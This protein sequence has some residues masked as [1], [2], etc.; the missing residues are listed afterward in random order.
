M[1]QTQTIVPNNQFLLGGDKDQA[2]ASCGPRSPALLDTDSLWAWLPE[3][4]SQHVVLGR[5]SC[6]S[7]EY[8]LNPGRGQGSGWAWFLAGGCGCHLKA[9]LLS[10]SVSLLGKQENKYPIGE[11]Q[12]PNEI[13]RSRG[14]H[15]VPCQS[16]YPSTWHG[17]R[18][19]VGAQWVCNRCSMNV[20]IWHLGCL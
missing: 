20:C 15:E 13:Q 11:I 18:R 8:T 17:T 2:G 1:P 10:I 16:Y 12:P 3:T 4:P 9:T 14:K 19:A 6:E 5:N 7:P